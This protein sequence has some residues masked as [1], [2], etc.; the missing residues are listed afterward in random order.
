[1]KQSILYLEQQSWKGGAQQ[2][3]L[4][5]LEALDEDFRPIVAFPDNGPF[6]AYLEERGIETLSYPLGSYRPGKKSLGEML[7]FAW[8]SLWCTVR[9]AYIILTR[10]VCLVYI[11]GPRCLPSGVL[12]ARL[13]RRPV[14]FHLHIIL[15]RRADALLASWFARLASKVVACSNAAGDSLLKFRPSLQSKTKVLYNP[16]PKLAAGVSPSSHRPHSPNTIGMVG[17]ITEGKGHHILLDAVSMLDRKTRKACRLAI[18]GAP[19]PRSRED[20][21]YLG[22]LKAHAKG[23][24]I[25][26]QILWAGYQDD[27]EPFYQAMD[28]L[29]VPSVGTEGLPLVLLEAMQRGIPVIATNTGGTSEI[30]EHELNGLIVP[31]GDGVELATAL[32]KMLNSPELYKRLSDGARA[33]L[34]ARF[35]PE[36]FSLAMKCF[37]LKLCPPSRRNQNPRRGTEVAKWE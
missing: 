21:S 11:N 14:L 6:R 12:A 35:S 2:V 18:I 19:A 7:A 34:D 31:A 32:N 5:V 16:A 3:L 22:R 33:T 29:V 4:S 17:R 10:E 37:A 15:T 30:V 28:V 36:L 9:L 27:M 8:R 24:G 26:E 1:M 20:E 23:L 13:A 25:E